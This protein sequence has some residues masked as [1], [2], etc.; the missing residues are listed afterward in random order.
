MKITQHVIFN[1]LYVVITLTIIYIYS[2][3]F[4]INFTEGLSRLGVPTLISWIFLY[5]SFKKIFPAKHP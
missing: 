1:L 2:Y 5:T 3:I 4:D